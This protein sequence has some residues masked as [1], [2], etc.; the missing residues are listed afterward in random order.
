[1]DFVNKRK[2]DAPE[3]DTKKI[4]APFGEKEKELFSLSEEWPVYNLPEGGTVKITPWGSL[5]LWTDPQT[6]ETITRFEDASFSD[7]AFQTANVGTMGGSYYNGPQGQNHASA[8]P[9]ACY[10]LPSTPM[11][12]NMSS[13]SSPAPEN[14]TFSPTSEAELYVVDGYR[15]NGN[16]GA[17][18]QTVGQ[19][20]SQEQENFFGMEEQEEYSD[21]NDT[22]M[23]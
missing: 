19:Q 21:N 23:T 8:Q 9:N 17:A 13:N 4:K 22:M 7:L 2:R 1:M 6:G 14:M 5:R 11:S 12:L 15:H 10:E 18:G 20:F 3:P 16:N